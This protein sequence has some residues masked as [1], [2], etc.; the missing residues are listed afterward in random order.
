M[1]LLIAPDKFK[2]TL[3][4]EQAAEIESKAIASVLP[5]A[6][7]LSLPLADGGEGT[8]DALTRALNGRRESVR[9]HDPLGR[10]VSAFYGMAGRTAIL[11]MAAAS[12]MT[13]LTPGERNPMRTSTYGTGE[14]ILEALKQGAENMLIGIGGSATVD[15]GA[16]MA[17]ALGYRFY[18]AQ[19]RPLHALRGE[20]L[21]KIAH[22]DGSAVDRSLFRCD[23]RIASDVTNP[24]LGE[25]G[26]AAV[27]AP[28]KGATPEMIPLLEEGLRNLSAVLIRQ[29]MID[30]ADQPGD[31]A[32]GGLGMGLRAFCSA[33]IESGARLAMETTRFESLLPG[34]DYVITGEGCTDTQTEHG[35][36]CA[37]I[38][39]VCRKHRVK[40]ILLS[41]AVQG[42]R[43]SP[44]P[45]FWKTKAATPAG[46]PF[47]EIRRNAGRFLSNAARELAEE[48]RAASR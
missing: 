32:A 45:L 48:L 4:A 47:E 7:I 20:S 21:R 30:R 24:L 43:E 6:E 19:N 5:E 44:A 18:D 25:E 17:E 46:L 31:G 26:A 11:E 8:V 27:F 38:A 42:S 28:Q 23:I 37:E 14:L 39:E 35:K 36:L 40:C 10:P 1:R 13:L 41:G 33:R 2:G 29:G 34:T 3:T 12:G 16:G 9:V 15:G 22:I